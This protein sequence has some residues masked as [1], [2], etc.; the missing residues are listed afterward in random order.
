MQ[1]GVDGLL[2]DKT[3]PS[4]KPPLDQTVIA[5]LID[6]TASPPP[7]ET[8]HWTGPPWPK[9]SGSASARCSASGM[10]TASS[11]AKCGSSNCPTTRTRMPS[12]RRLLSR[13]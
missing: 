4:R 9:R 8:T 11:R 5:R 12:D 2:R 6:L 13:G 7:G 1:A 10:L 3:R